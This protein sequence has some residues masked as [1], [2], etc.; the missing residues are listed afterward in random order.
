MPRRTHPRARSHLPQR[1]TSRPTF[2]ARHPVV[3]S[4]AID[5]FHQDLREVFDE[6]LPIKLRSNSEGKLEIPRQPY[7]IYDEPRRVGITILERNLSQDYIAKRN[8][9]WNANDIGRIRGDIENELGR[10]SLA[11]QTL[12]VN[13][14]EAVRLGELE[15]N[16]AQKLGVIVDQES[17]V[18][19]LLIAEHQV[20][21]GG[22]GQNLKKFKYPWAAYVPHMTVVRI[23]SEVPVPAR[24]E[25][26]AAVNNLLPLSVELQPIKFFAEQEI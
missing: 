21:F 4:E 22:L 8:I 20:I 7:R 9:R 25:M 12:S 6:I 10:L 17:P 3:Y 5:H 15:H 2:G 24:N 19:E 13:L 18:A 16:G 23:R 1:R 14:T 26:V 11:G